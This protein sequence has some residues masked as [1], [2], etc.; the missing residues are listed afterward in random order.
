[1][2]EQNMTYGQQNQNNIADSGAQVNEQHHVV[3]N[4]Y[5]GQ[6]I[7]EALNSFLGYIKQLD[8][9][10]VSNGSPVQSVHAIQ[11]LGTTANEVVS[12]SD[13][14]P[15]IQSG[16]MPSNQINLYN[17]KFMNIAHLLRDDS[18]RDK[19]KVRLLGELT[20]EKTLFLSLTKT[21]LNNNIVDSEIQMEGFNIIR[22]DRSERIGGGVCFY[23]KKSIN[24]T[25]LLSYSNSICEVLIAKLTN[26]DA[27]C[28]LNFFGH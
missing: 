25:T 7:N 16:L 8:K 22:C 11:T 28:A 19:S 2:G 1:M 9:K 24:Y 18:F 5:T 15:G 26:P 20:N 14:Q 13:E 10:N 21:F 6:Q 12:T 3:H 23:L 4:N 17:F 27:G